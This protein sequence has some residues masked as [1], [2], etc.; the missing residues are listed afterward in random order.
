MPDV[1]V[2]NDECGCVV[3]A[4]VAACSCKVTRLYKT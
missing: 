4:V 1:V 2:T 3:V